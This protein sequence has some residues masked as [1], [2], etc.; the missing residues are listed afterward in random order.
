MKFTSGK[1]FL[2]MVAAAV[3]T[4]LTA[5]SPSLS[6]ET[7]P[8]LTLDMAKKMADACEAYQAAN[9]LPKFNIA[10]V[11]RGADLV[12]FR[13]QD[14]AFLG[15]GKIALQKAQSSASVPVPTRVIAEFVYGKDGNPGP[16]PGLVHSDVVAFAGGLPIADASGALV[17]AIGVSGA[18]ADQDEDCAKAAVAAIADDLN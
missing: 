3:A 13:R 11:D 5:A 15:S 7:R 6:G 14:D 18:S 2:V 4:T 8:F 1:S 10:I 12:L 17:G 9:D 16:L